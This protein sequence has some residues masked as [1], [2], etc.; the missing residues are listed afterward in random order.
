[1]ISPQAGLVGGLPGGL[2]WFALTE[3]VVDTAEQQR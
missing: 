2:G 3:I 1:M